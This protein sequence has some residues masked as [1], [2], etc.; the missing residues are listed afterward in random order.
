MFLAIA[1]FTI[2]A[3]LSKA[4]ASKISGSISSKVVKACC[5]R[6]CD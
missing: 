5:V 6:P 1:L 4:V 2:D 3:A